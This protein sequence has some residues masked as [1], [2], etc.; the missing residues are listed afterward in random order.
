MHGVFFH[1][2]KEFILET[3]GGSETW[4]T[5]LIVSGYPYKVYFPVKEYPDKEFTTLIKTAA[6]LLDIEENELT[7]NFGEF[8]APRLLQFYSMFIKDKTWKSLELMKNMSRSIH[9]AIIRRNPDTQPPDITTQ[10]I[11]N[12]HLTLHYQSSR[13]YCVLLSGMIMGIGHYYGEMLTVNETECVHQ[14]ALECIFDIKR[15]K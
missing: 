10:P 9:Q 7:I 15:K 3:Y 6:E 12:N 13:N 2:Y 8:L 1:F 11:D 4:K 5:L 14:G